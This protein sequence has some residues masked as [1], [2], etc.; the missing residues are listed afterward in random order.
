MNVTLFGN[1]I[2][3]EVIKLR[4]GH[5]HVWLASLY[6]EEELDTDTHKGEH[7]AGGL[8]QVLEGRGAWAARSW[9]RPGRVL[10]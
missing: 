9:K 7:A 1:K 8:A 6:K 10:S 2:S 3:A 4:R 5:S